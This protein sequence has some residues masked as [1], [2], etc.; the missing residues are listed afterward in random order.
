VNLT[1]E[2]GRF[3]LS[4]G[5]GGKGLNSLEREMKGYPEK[6]QPNYNGARPVHPIITTIKWIR[7]SR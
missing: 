5:V 2:I 4:V 1:H 6:R 3:G 7:T